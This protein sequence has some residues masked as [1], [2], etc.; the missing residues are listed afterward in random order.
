[1]RTLTVPLAALAAFLLAATA[2]AATPPSTEDR[3]AA[4]LSTMTIQ[5]SAK[6][7]PAPGA[8]AA[9]YPPA[10]RKA[11]VEGFV[12]LRCL[13][14]PDGRFSDC[15][16]LDE[17]PKGAA[18]GEAALAAATHVQLPASAGDV[19]SLEEKAAILPFLFEIE[20][21][22]QQLLK[23]NRADWERKPQGIDIA[24]VYPEAAVRADREGNAVISCET[25][26]DG[27]LPKG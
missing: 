18:F 19:K 27:R 9:L 7:D 25:A 21:R 10:A 4:V 22:E 3:L 1:M 11:D 24:R 14:Q 5:A 8:L 23:P 26:A 13:G 2:T 6:H 15:K 12:N 17:D 16:V 20:E